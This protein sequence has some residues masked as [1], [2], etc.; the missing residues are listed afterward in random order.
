MN[1]KIIAAL[2]V[3]FFAA[4]LVS[5]NVIQQAAAA[6]PTLEQVLNIVTN[7]Q[8]KVNSILSNTGDIKAELDVVKCNAQPRTNV[9]LSGCN[10]NG[11]DL[12]GAY[13]GGADLRFISSTGCTGTPVGTPALGSLPVC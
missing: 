7:I 2:V 6:N 8:T 4:T 10:L 12:N 11:A 1:K 5:S 13:F 9:D 3:T